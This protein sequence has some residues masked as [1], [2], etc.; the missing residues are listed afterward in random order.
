M[1]LGVNTFGLAKWLTDDFRADVDRL[2]NIGYTSVEINVQIRSG[3]MSTDLLERLPEAVRQKY[4][5]RSRSVWDLQTA[6]KKVQTIKENGL[7]VDSM[8]IFGIQSPQELLAGKERLLAFAKEN[9]IHYICISCFRASDEEL[10]AYIPVFSEYVEACS[11]EGMEFV[12]HNHESE[13][14]GKC[15]ANQIDRLLKKCPG[16]KIEL[17]VGWAQYGG[18]EGSRA[19]RRYKDSIAEIHL[20]DYVPALTLE[21]G[22]EFF[23]AIGNGALDLKAL[24]EEIPEEI[25]TSD[26]LI[27]DLDDAA[28]DIFED[29]ENS[30][31]NVKRYIKN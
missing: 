5:I 10:Y 16:I 14:Q 15:E 12:Y 9:K 23:C 4:L 31:Q 3:N 7:A 24:F 30:C 19:V 17:D 22:A 11:R 18:M 29:L 21:D 26:R 8:H 6:G 2:K 13:F 1:R 27:V 28:G 25:K 20:K